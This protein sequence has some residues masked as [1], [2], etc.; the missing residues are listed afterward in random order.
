MSLLLGFDTATD[1]LT[2][3]V[4]RD[5]EVVAEAAH[6]PDSAGRPRHSAML[7]RETEAQVEA[8]GGWNGIGRIAVGIGPGSYTGLRIGIATARALAQ[9]R[10]LPLAGVG[11]LAAIAAGIREGPGENRD[12]LAVLDASR[13]QAFAALHAPGGEEIWP[14]LVASPQELADR[15]RERGGSPLAAGDGSLRFRQELVDA[16]VEVLAAG[17]EAHLVSARHIC[18]LGAEATVSTPEAI[19]P[20]YLREPDAKRWQRRT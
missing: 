19:E 6:G 13:G 12:A 20:I 4:T 15:V 14:P 8:A 18:G 16:G 11:T 10:E 1:R 3:A 7:L 17:D 5:G 2:V 9:G